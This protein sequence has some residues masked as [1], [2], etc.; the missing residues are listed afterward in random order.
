M[1][2]LIKK[3]MFSYNIV[4]GSDVKDRLKKKVYAPLSVALSGYV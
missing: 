4:Y 2:L 3:C 1:D